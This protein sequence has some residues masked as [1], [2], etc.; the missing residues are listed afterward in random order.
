MKKLILIFILTLPLTISAQLADG[1]VTG[2]KYVIDDEMFIFKPGAENSNVYFNDGHIGINVNDTLHFNFY[3]DSPRVKVDGVTYFDAEVSVIHRTTESRQTFQDGN[4]GI[5]ESGQTA[6]L[7]V[8]FGK[9]N[10]VS[11]SIIH[12]L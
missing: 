4:L 7:T 8:Y 2:M 6:V 9:D 3:F 5:K 1:Y 12:T 10:S 11:F